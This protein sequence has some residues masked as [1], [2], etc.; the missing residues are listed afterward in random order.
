MLQ[1]WQYWPDFCEHIDR[2][3]LLAD[4]R[5]DSAEHLMQ[6]TAAAAQILR[7]TLA[8]R[9]LAEWSERFR[10]LK[11][12]W[13]PVQNTTEVAAD[14]QVRANGYLARA[15]T[16]GGTSF[17]LVASPVQFDEVPTPTR[18]GPEFNE[19]GDE[20][21]LSLGLSMDHII[22]LKAAGAIA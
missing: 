16:R 7:E 22:E 19:H 17:E 6:N 14:P 1:A 21:L 11:G 13:A 20:I 18:R 9:T 3:D 8:T 4:P 10:T 15:E 2:K 12:Q 5:F